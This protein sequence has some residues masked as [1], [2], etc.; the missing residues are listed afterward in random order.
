MKIMID[1][2]NT[3]LSWIGGTLSGLI[4]FAA[5]MK[6]S[7]ITLFAVIAFDFVTGV[8]ASRINGIGVSSRRL[9]GSIKKMI[10]YFEVVFI[11][12]VVE[13]GFDFEFGTYRFI[14]G[15]IC[16][17]EIISILENTAVITG[18]KIF[19]AIVKLLRGKAKSAYG[20]VADEILNEKND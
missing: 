2:L 18:N 1:K 19:M 20:E 10:G 7:F 11:L 15:F 17:I 13:K 12:F 6:M 5:P 4:A 9:R 14:G 16:F 8:W 3:L